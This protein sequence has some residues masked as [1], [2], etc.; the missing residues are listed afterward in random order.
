[1][2]NIGGSLLPSSDSRILQPIGKLQVKALPELDTHAL[3]YGKSIVAIHPNGYSC[4]ALAERMVEGDKK[5]SLEQAEYILACGGLA[6]KLDHIVNV[7]H[8]LESEK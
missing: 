7:I 3:F 4:R 2:R 1:M 8:F 5:G 6:I